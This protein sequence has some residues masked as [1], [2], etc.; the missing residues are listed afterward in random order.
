M[1][2]RRP[3]PSGWRLCGGSGAGYEVAVYRQQKVLAAALA[4]NSGAAGPEPVK[5]T[6]W[7]QYDLIRS[8]TP[9]AERALEQ[10]M[11]FLEMRC[12]WPRA[13][14]KTGDWLSISQWLSPSLPRAL[15]Q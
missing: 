15:S 4:R 3:A 1:E 2:K 9:T 10:V 8:E 14:G 11:G 5:A 6:V 13:C 12:D 7:A